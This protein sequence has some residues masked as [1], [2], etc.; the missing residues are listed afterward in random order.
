MSDNCFS[1]TCQ[2]SIGGPSAALALGTCSK[3]DVSCF[4]GSNGS[5]TAGAVTN[6]VGAVSYSWKNAANTVVGTTSTV[7]NLPAGTYTLTVSDNCF[8]QTCQVSIGGPSAALALGTCSK[9]DVSCFGGSNGSVTAGAVTN[10]VGAVSYSWKNAAN[11]VVG[12]TSTVSNLPAGTYTLTVSDNCFSQTCQVSIGGPSAALALGTC[13]KTDVSCFG[14][15]N[16]SVT[17]GAVTN[18]VGAVSYSWKNAANTVVGTTSTVSNLPAGTYTLTV[19][20]NCFSRTCQVSIGG[21]SAA[22]ALGTC[23]KTDVT[24]S[25]ENTGSVTAGAVTN[26][27]GA[28]SYSWKNAANTVVGTT[29]TVSNLPAGTYTLT[30]SDNCSSQS[31]QVTV[32]PATDC[33]TPRHIF[34]TETSCAT[35]QAGAAELPNVC[36]TVKGQKISNAT[37]GVFFYYTTITAPGESFIVVVKQTVPAGG[38]LPFGINQDQIFAWSAN[39]CAKIASGT[40]IFDGIITITNATAGQSIVLSAKYDTKTIIGSDIGNKGAVGIYRFETLI[41]NQPDQNSVGELRVENCKPARIGNVEFF[42]TTALKVN[43]YPNPY[44]GRVFLQID[45]PVAGTA[46]IDMYTIGGTKVDALKVNVQQGVN[47]PVGYD[48]KGN[49]QQLLYRVS[50]G[51]KSVSG[52]LLSGK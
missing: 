23:S 40:G 32:N 37:P 4:G 43:A 15:S 24:C 30:V 12:T 13:S 36:Y 49:F 35:Y 25:G 11:T 17:A 50:V 22:L 41:N 19:S 5:V 1:Q 8:S 29:S 27:V 44:N 28:V 33:V 6:A 2:V 14:G 52:I 16:G 46:D 34:P 18:A 31:C 47:E 3:T 26:A 38:F 10:A 9:T 51:G 42:E 45:S 48:V 7:S 20:D 21:P 39:G